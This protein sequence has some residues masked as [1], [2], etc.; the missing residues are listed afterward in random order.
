MFINNRILIAELRSNINGNR[1]AAETFNHVFAH[2]SG[3]HCRTAGSD[4]NSVD[5][6][7][8]FIT[9][10]VCRKIRKSVY[11]TRTNGVA[12]CFRLFVDFFH[13]EI[14]I[15]AFFCGSHIP[16]DVMDI[17]SVHFAIFVFYNDFIFCQLRNMTFF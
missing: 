11:H 12:E 17:R 13:H 2:Q 3:M 15:T 6:S 8:K 10:A 7:E 9:N 1:N 5:I 16:A 14:I 4:N